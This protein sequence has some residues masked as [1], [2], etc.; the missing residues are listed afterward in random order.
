MI[1]RPPRSTLFPYTT[2]FRS[3]PQPTFG[4]TV[5]GGGSIDSS[6]LFTAGGNGGGPLNRT[7]TGPGS[8]LP[9]TTGVTL[10]NEAPTL[11]LAPAPSPRPP[12]P[13]TPTHPSVPGAD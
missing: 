1:R 5:S 3:V 4:W 8:G 13:R 6:G 10:Q 7:A 12:T 2:L 11:A 9:G